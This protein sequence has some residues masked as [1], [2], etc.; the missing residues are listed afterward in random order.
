MQIE[1][2]R[3][4]RVGAAELGVAAVADR[5]ILEAPVDDQVDER[6]GGEDAVGDE[7]ALEPVEAALMTMPMMTTV[8]P[9]FG[10]KSLRP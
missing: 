5:E 6:R 1:G 2:G 3:I 9:I 8:R 4:P 7:I 10:S